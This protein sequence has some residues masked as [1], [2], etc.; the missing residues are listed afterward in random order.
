MKARQSEIAEFVFLSG[1]QIFD[2]VKLSALASFAGKIREGERDGSRELKWMTAHRSG[3][4]HFTAHLLP[5]E[6]FI[7]ARSP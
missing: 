7:H 6:Y 3:I 2:A 1:V 4:A 5:M